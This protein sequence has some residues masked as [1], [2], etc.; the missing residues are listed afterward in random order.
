[1]A[2]DGV[3]VGA[4]TEVALV[5]RSLET[6]RE[7]WA[8]PADGGGPISL[9]SAPVIGSGSEERALDY[10]DNSPPLSSPTLVVKVWVEYARSGDE[11]TALFVQAI[12]LRP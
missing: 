6:G 7:L 1:M 10:F 9:A 11:A 2:T 3:L 8:Y 12:P 4:T 5:E